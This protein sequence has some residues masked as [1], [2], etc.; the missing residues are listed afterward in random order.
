[1]DGWIKQVERHREIKNIESRPVINLNIGWY[2]QSHI[3]KYS[4][5]R[6]KSQELWGGGNNYALFCQENSF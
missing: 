4:L 1:M 2:E 5:A 6:F 3:R